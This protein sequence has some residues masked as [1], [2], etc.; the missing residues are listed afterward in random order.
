MGLLG[1]D[2]F[3]FSVA[4][5]GDSEIRA[6]NRVFRGKDTSTDVLSFSQIDEFPVPGNMPASSSLATPKVLGDVVISVETALR[7][8]LQFGVAPEIRLRTLLIHGLLHLLDYDHERSRAAARRM[9]ARE[10][11]LAAALAASDRTRGTSP[12]PGAAMLPASRARVP[13]RTQ[14]RVAA[15]GFSSSRANTA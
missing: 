12:R 9:F 15:T 5:V 7:Q 6:L 3:E 2:P 1:L 14:V 13:Q 11:D 8:A 4:L 10:R